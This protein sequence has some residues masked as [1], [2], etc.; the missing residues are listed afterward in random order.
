MQQLISVLA[1]KLVPSAQF[2][3]WH[4]IS[5]EFMITIIIMIC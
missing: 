5:L 2:F 1:N 4:S 3:Y